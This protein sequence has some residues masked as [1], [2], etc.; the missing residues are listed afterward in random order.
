MVLLLPAGHLAAQ[1]PAAKHLVPAGEFPAFLFVA[2]QPI[3]APE[4]WRAVYDDVER[5]AGMKGD[6]DQIRWAVMEAPLHGPNGPTYAFNVGSRIV[7][8][9]HNTT[10]LRHEMLHHILQVAG[11]EPRHLGPG[12]HYTVAD[13]HPL[14]V[15]DRCAGQTTTLASANSRGTPASATQG[16]PRT[17][18]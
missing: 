14:P 5:C 7:L 18:Q 15:F 6:Y 2:V 3:T 11:W 8:V 13:L 12:E 16:E 17:R 4:A 10:Y 1:E 9:R